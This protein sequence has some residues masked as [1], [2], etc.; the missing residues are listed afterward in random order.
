MHNQ[1]KGQQFNVL[2][3]VAAATVSL[4]VHHRSLQT[5]TAAINQSGYREYILQW[6]DQIALLNAV[7]D[8]AITNTV[9]SNLDG[10]I[11][12]RNIT[13]NLPNLM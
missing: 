12:H 6:Q 2:I 3:K 11:L 13:L 4:Q 10:N 5:D 7:K 1:Q 9:S 8:Y